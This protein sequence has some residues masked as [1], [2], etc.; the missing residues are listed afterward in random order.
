MGMLTKTTV[1]RQQLLG[2]YAFLFLTAP[3]VSALSLPAS[4]VPSRSEGQAT[5]KHFTAAGGAG[6]FYGWPANNGAWTWDGGREILVGFSYGRFVEQEGH[7]TLE[8]KDYDGL[9]RS[10][11]GGITWK[12]ESSATYVPDGQIR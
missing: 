12:I 7:N 6:N 9:A 10:L 1:A 2:V 4:D 8:Q 5:M 11:D 3:I